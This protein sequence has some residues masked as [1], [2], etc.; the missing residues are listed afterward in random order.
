[1]DN[2]AKDADPVW[3]NA[4]MFGEDKVVGMFLAK[5]VDVNTH[6]GPHRVT[7]LACAAY[8]G[9]AR[10]AQMLIDAGANINAVCSRGFTALQKAAYLGNTSVVEVLLVAGADVN[11]AGDNG[12]H[13]MYNAMASPCSDVVV[14]LL[15][16]AGAN[17][18][19][20]CPDGSSPLHCAARKGGGRHHTMRLLINAGADVNAV[21]EGGSTPLHIAA[22]HG[23]ADA[24]DVLLKAGARH[25]LCANGY[26]PLGLVFY[27]GCVARA[28]RTAKLLLRS[29]ADARFGVPHFVEASVVIGHS[30]GGTLGAPG[31]AASSFV[32]NSIHLFPNPTLNTGQNAQARNGR[33]KPIQLARGVG[34]KHGEA[35]GQQGR[36]IRH[37]TGHGRYDKLVA[38]HAARRSGHCAG[39]RVR[40]RQL[41]KH[42]RTG[43]RGQ[44]GRIVPNRAS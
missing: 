42:R 36:R 32:P 3:N 2:W 23:N 15:L 38:D 41:G 26:S 20:R 14:R 29:G 44:H 16:N 43:V 5:G 34:G 30:C 21:D 33:P 28:R 9:R 35:W 1:M 27:G 13:A 39:R 11:V 10:I 12:V 25:I 40:S 24:I 6:Y 7:A 37:R 18:D 4:I 19:P 22:M 31:S 17:P 8:N